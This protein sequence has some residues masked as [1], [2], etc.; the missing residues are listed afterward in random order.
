[1]QLS[2]RTGACCRRMPP[3]S[4]GRRLVCDRI[5]LPVSF[6]LRTSSTARGT[7]LRLFAARA[8]RAR[9]QSWRRF[10]LSLALTT[11]PGEQVG[12]ELLV[13]DG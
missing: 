1:M 11:A 3:S 10:S 13:L 8:W 4:T 9:R 7:D 5:F 2:G 12:A 6:L